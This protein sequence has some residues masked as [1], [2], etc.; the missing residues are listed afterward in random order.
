MFEY[1]L[2]CISRPTT[3]HRKIKKLDKRDNLTQCISKHPAKIDVF[4]QFKGNGDE[5]SK[6]RKR[7][8]CHIMSD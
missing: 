7:Q 8:I 6:I 1:F 5:K 3:T 2:F 4:D